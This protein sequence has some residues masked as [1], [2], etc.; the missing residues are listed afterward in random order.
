MSAYMTEIKKPLRMDSRSIRCP[1]S[2]MDKLNR[3]SF[4]VSKG[5]DLRQWGSETDIAQSSFPPIPNSDKK[6]GKWSAFGG[7]QPIAN[8][9]GTPSL[10]RKEE[11]LLSWG[12]TSI[13]SPS[14]STQRLS[15]SLDLKSSMT[16]GDFRRY[17]SGFTDLSPEGCSS[18]RP[19]VR[20]LPPS[21]TAQR[22]HRFHRYISQRLS[23]DSEQTMEKLKDDRIMKWIRDVS[24]RVQG[25]IDDDVDDE[26]EGNED[27]FR[28]SLFEENNNESS[29]WI[30][31]LPVIKEGFKTSPNN[32]IHKM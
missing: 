20:S 28:S 31:G 19:C 7:R 22:S 25:E 2:T 29:N 16:V 11:S 26:R 27:V 17:S 15:L 14:S 4:P 24:T 30:A 32:T 3:Y 1:S 23:N 8:R 10:G 5:V 21:P 9:P 6:N 12:K 13:L 18:P